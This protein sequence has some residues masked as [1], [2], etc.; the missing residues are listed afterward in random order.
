[1]EIR[2]ELLCSRWPSSGV[3]AAD[4]RGRNRPHT[5]L[6]LPC[7]RARDTHG[8]ILSTNWRRRRLAISGAPLSGSLVP[9]KSRLRYRADNGRAACFAQSNGGVERH[10]QKGRKRKQSRKC[11][12]QLPE[13]AS[14][15]LYGPEAIVRSFPK[16]HE[17]NPDST[18]SNTLRSKLC[19]VQSHV[20]SAT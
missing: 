8:T 9:N 1:M 5:P 3:A 15:I 13:P 12:G 2:R 6:L 17:A 19:S 7:R 16:N 18:V 4:N 11:G 20:G 10:R 14:V